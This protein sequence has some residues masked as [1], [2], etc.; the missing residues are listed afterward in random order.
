MSIKIFLFLL[1]F[2]FITPLLAQQ[3]KLSQAVNYLSQYIASEHFTKLKGTNSDLAL[4]DSIYLRALKFENYNYSESLL[5][6]IFTTVPYNK[7]PI[8]FPLIKIKAYYPLTSSAD[9]VFLQ[10]NKNLPK[11]L[12]FDSPQNDFGDKDK[13][14][15]FF[16]SAFLS[17]STLFLDLSSVIGYFVEV[18]E[19]DFQVQSSID[20]R[21]LYFDMIGS[22]F[23]KML[24]EDKSI[25]PS[26]ILAVI[27][28]ENLSYQFP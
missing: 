23:G 22:Q 19:Q 7:V 5:A 10:K 13:L 16:G 4:V 25:L 14:A 26:Q 21:D 2:T 3:S 8:I 28:S 24:K 6:L 15:H 27:I 9:S 18:F 1:T 17:Y 11:N 12:A 20:D